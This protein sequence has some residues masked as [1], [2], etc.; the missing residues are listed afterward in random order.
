MQSRIE[1]ESSICSRLHQAVHVPFRHV[2]LPDWSPVVA[3][4]HAN[5]DRWVEAHSEYE[6]VRGWVTYASFGIATGLTAHS[7]VCGP[8]GQLF[9]ITPLGNEDYRQSMRFVAHIGDD[10]S[11]TAMKA[12]DLFIKCQEI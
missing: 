9:D 3:D 7:V 12:A 4:C 5:V 11:F 10:T 2:S 8:D 1:Y 6:P